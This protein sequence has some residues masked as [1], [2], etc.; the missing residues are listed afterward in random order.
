MHRVHYKNV[1][2]KYK[3]YGKMTYDQYEN[4]Q[5]E[6]YMYYSFTVDFSEGYTAETICITTATVAAIENHSDLFCSQ[7]GWINNQTLL[8]A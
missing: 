3:I 4:M 1:G 2:S 5:T 6:I 7:S 8:V